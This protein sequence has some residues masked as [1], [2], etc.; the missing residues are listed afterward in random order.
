MSRRN[1]MRQIRESLRLYTVLNLNYSQIAR[2]V[3][4]GRTS[5]QDYVGRF[6]KSGLSYEELLS[7]NEAEF[8]A[9]LYPEKPQKDKAKHPLPDFA[10]LHIER[11]KPGVT[12]YL[13]WEEYRQTHP[14]GLSYSHFCKHYQQWRGSLNKTMRMEHK[15]GEKVFV[16]YSGDRAEVIDPKT[17][18]I[19][20]VEL[21]VMCWGA[22]NYIYV[23][24]HPT[25][26]LED[27][28]MGHVRGFEY[29]GKVPQIVVPDNLKSAVSKCCRYDPELN[30]SYQELAEQYGVAVIPARPRKPK[31]KAKVENSVLIVQRRI[32]APLRNQRFYSLAEL[33]RAIREKLEEL[34]NAPMQKL[35]RSREELFT[36]VDA[37][38]ARD[39]PA[40]RYTFSNWYSPKIGPDYHVQVEK[41]YY[42]VPCEYYGKKIDVQVSGK[43]V[44]LFHGL[45]RIATHIKAKGSFQTVTTLEHLPPSQQHIRSLTLESLKQKARLYGVHTLQLV[46]KIIASKQHP[47]QAMRPL[48][49]VLRLGKRYT[50]ELLEQSSQVALKYGYTR[51]REIEGVLKIALKKGE[52]EN[53]KTVRNSK[54]VRGSQYYAER[55]NS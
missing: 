11:R 4:I 49:G 37:P 3:K 52:K 34:N 46:E 54:Q 17:G 19:Q 42:S 41:N 45:N 35:K 9:S 14:L 22:S 44:T 8:M 31:D 39:L 2:A 21:F 48:Q 24:A 51:V 47:L 29:F 20:K 55:N 23:E 50:P 36:E 30:R 5:V 16:D 10:S 15:G 7:L 33:N 27:W 1:S 32:L 12:T 6:K 40:Q 53:I 25:Q 43:T 38:F 13:L 28:L 18:E 26:R